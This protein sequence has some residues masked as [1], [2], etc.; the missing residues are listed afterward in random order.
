MNM[1]KFDKVEHLCQVLVEHRHALHEVHTQEVVGVFCR[2]DWVPEDVCIRIGANR[3]LV[4]TGQ[5]SQEG[6]ALVA[7]T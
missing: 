5:G 3:I 7:R 1:T 6:W 2:M 4:A